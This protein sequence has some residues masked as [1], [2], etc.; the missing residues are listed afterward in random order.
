MLGLGS[1]LSHGGSVAPPV[2]ANI[3]GAEFFLTTAGSADSGD[4]TVLAATTS[5]F[6]IRFQVAAASFNE[7]SDSASDFVLKNVTV[8]NETTGAFQLI[9][10]SVT[11]DNFVDFGGGE[12]VYFFTDAEGDTD[13]LDFGSS[14]GAA[15]A[16]YGTSNNTFVISGVL[17][18]SGVAGELFLQKKFTLNDSDG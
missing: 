17:T 18:K 4:T 10:S 5:T 3:V 16:H 1:S 14:S 15:C 6:D 13:N 2:T 11:M 9:S 7:S 12:I 8:E